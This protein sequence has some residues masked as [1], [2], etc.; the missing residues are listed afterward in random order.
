LNRSNIDCRCH[1][2][3]VALAESILRRIHEGYS[4]LHYTNHHQSYYN[5]DFLGDTPASLAAFSA[6]ISV[7]AVLGGCAAATF[8]GLVPAI[9]AY[10]FQKDLAKTLDLI[11][12]TQ[13]GSARR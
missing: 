5:P 6:A 10:A 4:L 13:I 7:A 8:L 2:P 12:H 3:S 11:P 9:P 1:L